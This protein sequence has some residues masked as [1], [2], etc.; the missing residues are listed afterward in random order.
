MLQLCVVS[1]PDFLLALDDLLSMCAGHSK[2]CTASQK[3]LEFF[4]KKKQ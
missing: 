4:A 3:A 2:V 1:W